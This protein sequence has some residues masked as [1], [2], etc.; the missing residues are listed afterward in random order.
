MDTAYDMKCIGLI[1]DDE[2]DVGQVHLGIVHICDV[3]EPRVTP[4]ESEI[5]D[6]GFRPVAELLEKCNLEPDPWCFPLVGS[7]LSVIWSRGAGEEEEIH[8]SSV[9]ISMARREG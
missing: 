5:L 1:N 9:G 7:E 2:T 3:A 4:R 8:L 6:S